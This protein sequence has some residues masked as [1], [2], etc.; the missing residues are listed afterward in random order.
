M[1]PTDTPGGVGLPGVPS[2]AGSWL[3]WG[4]VPAGQ[5]PTSARSAEEEEQSGSQGGDAAGRVCPEPLCNETLQQ[6]PKPQLRNARGVRGAQQQRLP[7]L[8]AESSDCS[9]HCMT[10]PTPREPAAAP[11]LHQRSR[12]V[13]T[14]H[15]IPRLGRAIRSR[16]A[17]QG[18]QDSLPDPFLPQTSEQRQPEDIFRREG[19]K[20]REEVMTC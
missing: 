1:D 9:T 7:P 15:C 19:G 17:S 11:A 20:D 14:W 18:Q 10:S 2:A 4:K 16:Q 13:S 5:R 8:P 3:S 6:R 12:H